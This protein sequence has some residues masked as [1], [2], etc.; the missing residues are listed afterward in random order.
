[1][2]FTHPSKF[3]KISTNMDRT[4]TYS[5][6]AT[7]QSQR[8]HSTSPIDLPLSPCAQ[9][10]PPSILNYISSLRKNSLTVTTR[11]GSSSPVPELLRI[12]NNGNYT[13]PLP[14]PDLEHDPLRTSYRFGS[15]VLPF[16]VP[17]RKSS[18]IM[19]SSLQRP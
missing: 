9:D 11:P 17:P 1:M 3:H 16:Q 2:D 10:L 5:T 14:S 4:S 7:E 19:N 8:T 18:L 12:H 15:N 6:I 13:T